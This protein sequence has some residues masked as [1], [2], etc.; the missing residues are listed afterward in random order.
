MPQQRDYF[1][2][3][4]FRRLGAEGL[5]FYL[6]ETKHPLL[7]AIKPLIEKST[8]KASRKELPE[9]IRQQLVEAG[10]NPHHEAD[11][12]AFLIINDLAHTNAH[13]LMVNEC[14]LEGV[15]IPDTVDT[16]EAL[17]VYLYLKHPA[18]FEAV[19]VA[20]QVNHATGWRLFKASFTSP[21]HPWES[22]QADFEERAMANF[23]TFENAG[24]LIKAEAYNSEERLLI[25]VLYQGSL[26]TLED[27]TDEAEIEARKLHP[28]IETALV[29]YHATG[30]LKVKTHL[31]KESLAKALRN[32]FAL[33]VLETP[34][35]LIDAPSETVVN[36]ENL[37]TCK[38]FNIIIEN[39]PLDTAMLIE[40]AFTPSKNS[41][42]RIT[43]K[44]VDKLL[45]AFD[46]YN[47][48]IAQIE[49]SKATFRFYY[50]QGGKRKTTTVSITQSNHSVS[51]DTTDLGQAVDECFRSWGL[52]SSG[53]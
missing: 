32:S 2:K 22:A 16:A 34:M 40:L 43:I 27:F 3:S 42:R 35:F 44:D 15:E 53:G 25:H 41:R 6:K 38:D 36:L 45:K 33:S 17:A 19:R 20:Y 29:Y 13:S 46:E 30:L 8:T 5:V 11:K 31:N 14:K 52:I 4:L 50:R 47:I 23:K 1:E 48:P 28:P 24:K 26:K 12:K 37:K 21:T 18:I 39:S 49:I 7:K 10:N 9:I 51:T